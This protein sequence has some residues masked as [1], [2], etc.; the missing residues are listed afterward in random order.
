M[1]LCVALIRCGLARATAETV[2]CD[3]RGA[4]LEWI[5]PNEKNFGECG[6]GLPA[7]R[8]VLNCALDQYHWDAL[9]RAPGQI[10][11]ERFCRLTAHHGPGDGEVKGRSDAF[12]VTYPT[13]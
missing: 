4:V 8:F 1:A 13:R 6:E 9:G 3:S 5:V 12:G 7:L 10:R 2:H 11:H